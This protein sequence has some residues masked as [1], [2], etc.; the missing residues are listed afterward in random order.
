M[1]IRQIRVLIVPFALLLALA[2]AA[3]SSEPPTPTAPLEASTQ[4][5]T[6]AA[7]VAP[8][9]VSTPAPPATPEPA[10]KALEGVRGIV[11]P[12]NFGWPRDV[13]GLNGIVSIPSKPQRI[14]T[15]SVGHDEITLALVP[16]DRLV[17]VGGASKNS[18]YSNIASLV[19]DTAEITRDPETIIAQAPD[20]VVTSP[21]FPT[22][23]IEALSKT[24]IPVV[25]TEL[26]H[27]PE[28][29]ITSILFMGYI[30]G[31]EDRAFEFAAEVLDRYDSL[32][33]VTGKSEPR[34]RV[35]ALTRYSEKLWVAGGNSTEGGVIAA[36]G[37]INAA[38]EAGIEGNQTTSLEGVIAMDPE[39]II[40]V[41]PLEFGA[42]ELR[43]SLLANEALAETPAIKDNQVY[44]VESKHFT[45]LS[46]WNLRGAEDLARLLWPGDFPEPSDAPFSLAG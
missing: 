31:E 27:D 30:F 40:I 25:Q 12:T 34:P 28:A 7:I 23:T 9:A 5:P 37:G 32:V 39:V 14:V 15:A 19:Q 26:K 10:R 29:R 35:L 41:Q 21:F 4:A 38:E 3:C 1:R 36:A 43:Q 6:A 11:D 44:L 17:G 24:G 18:T 33:A 2:L 13:E 22:E 45:T 46:Y 20:V 16:R 42:E 8:T